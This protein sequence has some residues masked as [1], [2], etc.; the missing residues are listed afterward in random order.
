[1]RAAA[2]GALWIVSVALICLV[3]QRTECK[4]CILGQGIRIADFAAHT[5]TR[6][7]N[8]VELVKI[9]DAADKRGGIQVDGDLKPHIDFSNICLLWE[10]RKAQRA[11]VFHGGTVRNGSGCKSHA[12]FAS[13]FNHRFLAARGDLHPIEDCD[14]EGRP[15]PEVLDLVMGLYDEFRSG[16]D[17][18]YCN[19]T[20]QAYPSA[21]TLPVGFVSQIS[22]P[23]LQ[24]ADADG[25][26]REH[27]YPRRSG[28]GYA[29]RALCG[30]LIGFLGFAFVKASLGC[31]D[32]PSPSWGWRLCGWLCLIPA[33]YL[34]AHAVALVVLGHWRIAP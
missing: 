34:V 5:K 1:M 14:F 12:A 4:S 17:V 8:V 19:L 7:M 18:I 25:Y 11:R 27:G 15:R 20:I 2:R 3:I 26:K 32:Q 30:V 6:P 28:G 9:G 13:E 21:L 33:A 24:P 29:A 10:E 22:N 23:G 16:V 31:V